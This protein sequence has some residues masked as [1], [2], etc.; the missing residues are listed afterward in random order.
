VSEPIIRRYHDEGYFVQR[1][2]GQS[3]VPAFIKRAARTAE[4]LECL[5]AYCRH[6]YEKLLI[7][8]R[9]HFALIGK[10]VRTWDELSVALQGSGELDFVQSLQKRL[11][12][13]LSF[14]GERKPSARTVRR[15]L[16]ELKASIEQFNR[17]WRRF[18]ERVDLLPVNDARAAYNRYYVL[19][20]E[21]AVRSLRVARQGFKPLPPIKVEDLAAEFPFL[22]SFGVTES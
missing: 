14:F 9:A 15:A 3:D 2:L 20:K 7:S 17:R 10:V 4:A 6:H 5:L 21:C 1:I 22:R 19:E 11:G 16:R 18:L 8:V 13:E 12:I